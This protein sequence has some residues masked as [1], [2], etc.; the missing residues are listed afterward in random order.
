MMKRSRQTCRQR[1][2]QFSARDHLFVQGQ[3]ERRAHTIWIERGCPE[4]DSLNDW[5]RAEREVIVN[6]CKDC[7]Y[8]L[9]IH[10]ASFG[11][12]ESKG[13]HKKKPVKKL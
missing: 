1:H 10:A 8:D 2:R 6:F 4:G 7:A 12:N 11:S 13:N 9:P 5:L 3:I